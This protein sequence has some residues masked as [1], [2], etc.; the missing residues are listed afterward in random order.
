MSQEA[1]LMAQRLDPMDIRTKLA[2][3][4][5]PVITGVKI[6]N[7]ITVRKTYLKAIWEIFKESDIDMFVFCIIKDVACVMLYR[8]EELE[9]YL[10]SKSVSKLL[11]EM[12]HIGIDAFKE[13]LKEISKKYDAYI[14]GQ[15]DFP[16]ELGL[17]L[18]Y[19][20]E[21]VSGFI[22]NCGQN[23]ICSGYW[24]VYGDEKSAK[25]RFKTYDMAKERAVR[26]LAAGGDIKELLN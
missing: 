16:H 12:G 24:K 7:L 22:E 23:Y 8:R 2:M 17:L 3:Q 15:G 13:I 4:C 11:V 9:K 18:G 20:P 10:E 26:V 25:M 1:R 21:D 6:S 14:K 19:P 5:A